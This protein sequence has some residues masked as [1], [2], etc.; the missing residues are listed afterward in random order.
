[1]IWIVTQGGPARATSVLSLDIYQKFLMFDLRGASATAM[2]Q[3]CISMLIT[4]FYLSRTNK[5]GA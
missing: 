5:E 2:L 4:V 1:V 3:L